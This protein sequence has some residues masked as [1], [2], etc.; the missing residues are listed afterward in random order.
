VGEG[1]GVLYAHIL[2]PLLV[3]HTHLIESSI[4]RTAELAAAAVD[5]VAVAARSSV[6]NTAAAVKHRGGVWLEERRRQSQIAAV[7]GPSPPSRGKR[8]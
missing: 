8:R 2:R 3:T 1:A 6:I 4:D 5:S 7:K